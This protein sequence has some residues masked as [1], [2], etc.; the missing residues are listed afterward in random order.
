MRHSP[1]HSRGVGEHKSRLPAGECV[2]QTPP[3]T[4]STSTAEAWDARI[5]PLQDDAQLRRGRRH[6]PLGS[7]YYTEV[8]ESKDGGFDE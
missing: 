6:D 5:G 1:D 7:H 2:A 3:A 8:N 4:S